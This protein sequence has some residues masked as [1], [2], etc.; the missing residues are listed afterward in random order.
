MK[1]KLFD[2]APVIEVDKDYLKGDEKLA[3]IGHE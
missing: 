1:L 2:N 3:E